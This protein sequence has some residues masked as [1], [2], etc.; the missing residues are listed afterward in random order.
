MS[1]KQEGEVGAGGD[2]GDYH[3]FSLLGYKLGENH[4]KEGST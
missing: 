4:R 2:F 1:T 3:M